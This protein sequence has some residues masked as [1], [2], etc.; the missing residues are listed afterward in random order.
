[1]SAVEQTRNELENELKEI[2]TEIALLQCRR[3]QNRARRNA[4]EPINALPDELLLH[5]FRILR[6]ARLPSRRNFGW[7]KGCLD[8]CSRWRNVAVSTPFLWQYVFEDRAEPLAVAL[9]RCDM[10][11]ILNWD[12]QEYSDERLDL[13]ESLSVLSQHIRRCRNIRFRGTRQHINMFLSDDNPETLRLAPDVVFPS[14]VNSLQD[15]VLGGNFAVPRESLK[16]PRVTFR[17]LS[18]LTLRFTPFRFNNIIQALGDISSNVPTVLTL[19]IAEKLSE[20]QVKALSA[21]C[22]MFHTFNSPVIF[23]SVISLADNQDK[24]GQRVSVFVNW[25]GHRFKQTLY[26]NLTL[27]SSATGSRTELWVENFRS[28]SPEHFMLELPLHEIKTIELNGPSQGN[29]LGKLHKSFTQVHTVILTE[30]N[31]FSGPWNPIDPI[32][33]IPA[34]PYPPN[35][36]TVILRNCASSTFPNSQFLRTFVILYCDDR[37]LS[38]LVI[39]GTTSPN[40]NPWPL[41]HLGLVDQVEAPISFPWNEEEEEELSDWGS[42][43][44][45]SEDSESGDGDEDDGSDDPLSTTWV[46]SPEAPRLYASEPPESSDGESEESAISDYYVDDMF[47]SWEDG[48]RDVERDLDYVPSEREDSSSHEE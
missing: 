9:R 32:S 10:P 8:V 21:A 19:E 6:D 22:L 7:T 34:C 33:K 24:I 3:Q 12:V 2:D 17:I 15:L 36:K 47:H 1:M 5:V 26:A 44:A 25:N 16:C 42:Q 30:M 37:P 20:T 14:L 29:L 31:R 11:F 45:I 38:R 43:S 35:L 4:L 13:K 46:L 41:V 40:F 18:S 28:V 27:L 48:I 23:D 39:E